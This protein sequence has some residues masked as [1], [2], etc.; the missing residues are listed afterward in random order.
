[1]LCNRIRMVT[2]YHISPFRFLSAFFT[3]HYTLI[4]IL[5]C[6]VEPTLQAPQYRHR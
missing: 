5:S 6:R 1:M 4:Q 2:A 3:Y